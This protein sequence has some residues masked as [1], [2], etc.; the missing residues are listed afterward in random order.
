MK[1]T[2]LSKTTSSVVV[3]CGYFG[4]AFC[5]RCIDMNVTAIKLFEIL[6]LRI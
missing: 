3:R 6:K 4:I 1:A 5:L 2:V